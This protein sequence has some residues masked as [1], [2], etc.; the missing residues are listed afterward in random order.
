MD[1]PG[2]LIH[3]D[4]QGTIVKQKQNPHTKRQNTSHEICPYTMNIQQGK[5]L[6]P[7]PEEWWRRW[8]SK[9]SARTSSGKRTFPQTSVLRIS[10]KVELGGN[11]MV[12][13]WDRVKSMTEEP[14]G[15]DA[16]VGATVPTYVECSFS[17]FFNLRSRFST[18]PR[19][20]RLLEPFTY[21]S[22]DLL[23]PLFFFSFFLH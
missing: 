4:K 3:I 20:P 6:P 9:I 21:R 10:I 17:N 19:Q 18:P 23:F 13:S 16:N 14:L 2:T 12:F 7:W 22:R 1:T 8:A 11:S 5:S 15:L